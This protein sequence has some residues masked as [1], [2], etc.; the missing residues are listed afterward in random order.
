MALERF[1]R[2]LD[3][4]LA[5]PQGVSA[6]GRTGIVAPLPAAALLSVDGGGQLLLCGGDRWSL[7]HLRSGQADLGFLADVAARH[8]LLARDDSLQL[9][10][11]WRLEPLCG[12]PARV[13]GRAL[14]AEGR[15]LAS[16]ARVALGNLEFLVRVPDAASAS[17]VLELCH[18]AE[19][20]G[21]RQVVLLAAGAGGRLRIAADVRAHVRVPG[22]AFE[23]AF[24][25]HARELRVF[26]AHELAGAVTGA[27]GALPFPPPERL[28]FS[29]GRPRGSRPPFELTLEPV[30]GL[31]PRRASP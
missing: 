14:A 20:A 1:F 9:G 8:A 26:S 30:P 29:C 10:P 28:A 16:G 31:A 19:C 27:S 3:R 13:D 23:L 18:G 12:E 6:E 7:G 5:A 21:A 22:L 15:R 24:E 4:A 17:W 2:W 25:W 11:G